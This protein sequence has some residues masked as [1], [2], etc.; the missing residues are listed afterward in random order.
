MNADVWPV[1]FNFACVVGILIYF[2]RKPFKQFFQ[3]RS[4]RVSQ[5]VTDAAAAKA[6]ADAE[7]S[8]WNI[9]AMEESKIRS[10][11]EAAAHSAMDRYREKTL[12]AARQ[13]AERAASDGGRLAQFEQDAARRRLRTELA[14]KSLELSAEYFRDSLDK[15]ERHKLVS[16]FVESVGH[17]KT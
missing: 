5:A 17:G 9:A 2:G 14:S 13:E 16:D 6:N 15:K 4:V 11:G 1:I 8:K 10:S 12:S 7:L 3:D